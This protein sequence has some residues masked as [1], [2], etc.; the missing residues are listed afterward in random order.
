MSV[1]RAPLGGILAGTV[2]GEAEVG[3]PS[4]LSHVRNERVPGVEALMAVW[5]ATPHGRRDIAA[6]T[7]ERPTLTGVLGEGLRPR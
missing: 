1:R 2:P 4:D 5:F 7:P 3:E 6:R